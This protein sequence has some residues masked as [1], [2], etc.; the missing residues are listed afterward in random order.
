[1]KTK[2]TK[3]KSMG[4]DI[5]ACKKTRL[6]SRYM[7]KTKHDPRKFEAKLPTIW[8]DGKAQGGRSSDMEKVRMEKVRDGE[9]QR[10]RKSEETRCRRAKR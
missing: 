9:D 3:V 2:T 5:Y 6:Y 7:Q 8:K 1:M 4:N 10:R